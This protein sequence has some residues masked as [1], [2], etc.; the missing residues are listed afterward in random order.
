MT[1]SQILWSMN[2]NISFKF[3]HSFK[4]TSISRKH[5]RKHS[6]ILEKNNN[7]KYLFF[8][9]YV[10]PMTPLYAHFP[11]V[12]SQL[13]YLSPFL[14][15]AW[16]NLHFLLQHNLVSCVP[17]LF[18]FWIRTCIQRLIRVL[19]SLF[20]SWTCYMCVQ[21]FS[22]VQL[23]ATRE[24][25]FMA[26]CRSNTWCPD[27]LETLASGQILGQLLECSGMLTGCSLW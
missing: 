12:S 23:F 1:A 20:T 6:F 24:L 8:S 2:L 14:H 4:I 25:V 10:F 18:F 9:F 22:H 16:H 17:E 7:M 26:I 13:T 27:T 11:L 5:L 15:C 19:P 21:L 3:H